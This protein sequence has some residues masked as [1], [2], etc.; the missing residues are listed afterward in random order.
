MDKRFTEQ[1]QK[2]VMTP[3]E[4]KD[5]DQGALLLLQLTGNKVMYRNI[6]MNPKGKAEFIEGKLKQYLNFRLAEVTHEEV[7]TMQKMVDV[8]VKETVK[9]EKEFAEFKAGKRTDHDN[10]PEEIQVLYKQN[11]DIVHQMRELHM[12]LRNLSKA[13]VTCPDSERY[14]FLKELIELDKQLRQNWYDYDHY[15]VGELAAATPQ[16]PSS[17]QSPQSP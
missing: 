1:L 8:I 2:W 6:S 16:S 17:P 15:K 4:E 12:Q 7:Q 9:P 13:N 5:W 10:L 14:P 11:L 3:A